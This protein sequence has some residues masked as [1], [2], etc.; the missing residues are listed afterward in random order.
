MREV[1][2]QLSPGSRHTIA[3][4]VGS[5]SRVIGLR[6]VHHFDVSGAAIKLI[7]DV[8]DGGEDSVDLPPITGEAAPVYYLKTGAS[9][10]DYSKIQ[11]LLDP[12]ST[13]V[14]SAAID[15]EI[16]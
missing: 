3:R 16:D 11:V 15:L 14:A 13:G 2:I 10:G 4:F 8:V 1:S 12:G 7:G 9:P 6:Y 5:G